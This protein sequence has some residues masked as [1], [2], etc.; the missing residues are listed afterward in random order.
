[1]SEPAPEYKSDLTIEPVS[2]FPSAGELLDD[3]E[4]HLAS[5]RAVGDDTPTGRAQG[6]LRTQLSLAASQI[7][8]A[9]F[10]HRGVIALEGIRAELERRGRPVKFNH[11]HAKPNTSAPSD[12]GFA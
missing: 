1:M 11:V 3:A 6:E 5:A 10:V 7:A 9:Q 2:S 4:M 8:L 12:E